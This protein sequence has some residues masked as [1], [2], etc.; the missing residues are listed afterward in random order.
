MGVLEHAGTENRNTQLA[1]KVLLQQGDESVCL[2][3]A[4]GVIFQM[5]AVNPTTMDDSNNSSRKKW[6]WCTALWDFI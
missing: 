5:M 6:L 1:V 3:E 2:A 4:T